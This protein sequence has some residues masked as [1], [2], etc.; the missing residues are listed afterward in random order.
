MC[1]GGGLL[2]T[3]IPVT[4]AS[5]FLNQLKTQIREGFGLRLVSFFS[6]GFYVGACNLFCPSFF[7]FC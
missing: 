3:Y 6:F 7:F 2:K 1:V 5:F 4:L